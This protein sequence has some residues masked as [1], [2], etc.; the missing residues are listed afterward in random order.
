M[1]P[2]RGQLSWACWLALTWA[3]CTVAGSGSSVLGTGASNRFVTTSPLQCDDG[4]AAGVALFDMAKEPHGSHPLSVLHQPRWS[5]ILHIIL[6]FTEFSICY[7]DMVPEKYNFASD[8]L[9]WRQHR[10]RYRWWR[11]GV[12]VL[13]IGRRCHLWR[14]D[15]QAARRGQWHIEWLVRWRKRVGR[16][17]VGRG[18]RVRRQL[19]FTTGVDMQLCR[20]CWRVRRHWRGRRIVI[21]LERWLSIQRR[22]RL[23]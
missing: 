23:W 3:A 11:V 13:S 22:D 7:R 15:L 2:R 20:R 10:R 1:P 14:R 8:P 21:Y 4:R 12:L 19:Q 6:A 5:M 16:R 9:H 17:F 18:G